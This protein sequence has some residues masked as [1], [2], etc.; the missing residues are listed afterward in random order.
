MGETMD[1]LALPDSERANRLFDELEQRYAQYVQSLPNSIKDVANAKSTYLGAH[2]YGAFE[3]IASLNPVLAGTPWLFWEQ[4]ADLEDEQFLA[5]AEA[6]ACLVIA[7]ILLDH[8]VD[9][10]AEPPEQATLLLQS[11]R[12]HAFRTYQSI[13]PSKSPFWGHFYRLERD[14]MAGLGLEVRAQSKQSPVTWEILEST[15]HGKVSPIICTVAAMAVALERPEMLAPMDQSLQHIA[16][17]SQLLDDIGDWRHDHAVGHQTYFLSEV[18]AQL[19][20]NSDE[21][22]AEA[23]QAAID[24]SWLDVDHIHLVM[25]WLDKSLAAVEG[26]SCQGWVDYVN[27]YRQLTDGHLNRAVARHLKRTVGP[28]VE[29]S[30]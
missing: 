14:H 6:G 10:Q 3:G 8:I 19:G 26:M 29:E 16:V 20:D 12:S 30:Q 22:D 18:D 17:A 9:G 1:Q 28:L 5:I 24:D 11:L 27:G 13:F 7:S 23:F 4:F 21:S 15:A 25:E 2:V